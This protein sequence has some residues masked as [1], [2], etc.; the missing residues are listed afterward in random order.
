[1]GYFGRP[2]SNGMTINIRY[3]RNKVLQA[4]RYHFISR[5]EIKIL[6]ILVNV[7][8]ILSAGLYA[9]KLI[10][11]QPFL[12]SSVLWFLL[13]LTFWFW[14]PRI[15]Y[16]RSATFK[17]EIALTFRDIDLLLETSRGYTTWQYNRFQYYIESPF[18][19]HLY[20]NDKSFFLLPK[21][22]C[23]GE[24]DTIDVRKMLNEKIGRK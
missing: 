23:V 8:A 7:F 4:L 13:M 24:A 12:M 15:I 6:L 1:M 17:E 10:R 5:S 2:I 18:F 3:D 14:L 9:F 16:R 11:P 19:F 21:D 22:C 20:I